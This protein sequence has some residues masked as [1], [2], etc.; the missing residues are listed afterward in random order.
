MTPST[1]TTPP[2]R[3]PALAMLDIADVPLGISALDALVKEADVEVYS[4]GT[5]QAGRYLILFGGEVAPVEESFGR[6]LAR[7]GSSV[8]DVVL[9]PYAEPRIAPAI[10]EAQQRW[11]SPGDTL[12]VLQTATSPIMLRV[13]DAALKGAEVDLVQLRIADGLGGRAIATLWG[14]SYDVEAAIE[15]AE[16]VVQRDHSEGWSAQAIRNVDPTVAE[17]VA[18]GT[19]F[20]GGWRG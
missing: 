6:A 15:L 12:G 10:L 7:A 20:F 1:H 2:T 18:E 8:T 14:E 4:A 11:Q 17:R 19:H 5:V 16:G 3:G 13:V 9:L